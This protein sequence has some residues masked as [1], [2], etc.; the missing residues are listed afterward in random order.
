LTGDAE[1]VNIKE[2]GRSALGASK[3]GVKALGGMG[4]ELGLPRKAGERGEVELCAL[5][6]K[7]KK[8]S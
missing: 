2:E 1:G 4:E 5:S 6:R 3:G 7:V 8:T